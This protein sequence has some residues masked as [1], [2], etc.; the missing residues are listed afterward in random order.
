VVKTALL[1][2]DDDP[3]EAVAVLTGNAKGD[4]AYAAICLR[5]AIRAG[6]WPRGWHPRG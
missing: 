2:L 6:A 4:R 1:A 5:V 3:D